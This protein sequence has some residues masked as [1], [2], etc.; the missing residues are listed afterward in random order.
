MRTSARI[1]HCNIHYS[2]REAVNT[3]EVVLLNHV[4]KEF[5]LTVDSF[6]S[7]KDLIALSPGV[8]LPECQKNW[9]LSPL[10][11]AGPTVSTVSADLNS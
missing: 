2:E 5:L 9:V 6:C 11:R 3:S 8:H 4:P 1:H 10:C 7:Q